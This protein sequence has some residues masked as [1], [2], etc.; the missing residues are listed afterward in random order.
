[1]SGGS[2][3]QLAMQQFRADF[4]RQLPERVRE[5]QGFLQAS[6]AHP[7]DEVPLCEL[8]RVVHKLAGSCGTFGLREIGDTAR[9]IEDQL[10]VL[11]GAG[12]VARGQAG[13]GAEQ[14]VV[15]GGAGG[16]ELSGPSSRGGAG[17]QRFTHSLRAAARTPFPGPRLRGVTMGARD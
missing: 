7:E 15:A 16:A 10:D 14:L 12:G 17:I 6:L 5:A 9:D 3:F 8:H 4:A 1:M 13:A 11:L 2:D